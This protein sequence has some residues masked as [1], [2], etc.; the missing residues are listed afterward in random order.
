MSSKFLVTGFQAFAG[1]KINPSEL[2]LQELM[3]SQTPVDTLL[4]PVSYKNAFPALLKKWKDDGPYEHLL[5]LG[6]AGGRD[7]VC[8]ERVALNWSE[9]SQPDEDGF[10]HPVG[11]LDPTAPT[12][13]VADFFPTDWISELGKIGPVSTSFTAGTYVCNSLYFQARHKFPPTTSILFVHLPYLPEQVAGKTPP[14][15]ASMD[16]KIQ[17]KIILELIQRMQSVMEF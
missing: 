7:Q 3:K 17:F 13:Y 12:S 14:V 11:P 2:L 10:R 4:L 9:T 15:A 8:L 16:L 6:L 1:D 5:L